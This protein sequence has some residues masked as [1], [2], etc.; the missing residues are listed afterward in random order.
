MATRNSR[1]A[2]AAAAAQAQAR[3]AQN[4]Q[5]A[6]AYSALGPKGPAKG[7]TPGATIAP[8]TSVGAVNGTPTGGPATPGA[9]PEDPRISGWYGDQLKSAT[10]A[11]DNAYY[12]IGY[13]LQEGANDYGFSYTQ[14]PSTG[15]YGTDLSVDPANPF[16]KM[17]LLQRSYEQQKAGT[18]NSYAADGQINS[19]AYQRMKRENQFQND[20]GNDE[21][22]KAFRR[23]L[24]GANQ[25][26]LAAADQYSASLGSAGS[27]ALRLALGG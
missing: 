1:T 22:K 9:A 7:S 17:A 25:D 16:S 27:E 6:A 21:L 20:A 3:Q 14:D 4:K 5:R 11:R 15:A 26:R 18:M 24:Q 19:G 2:A 23:L 12:S 10:T 8:G 13:N